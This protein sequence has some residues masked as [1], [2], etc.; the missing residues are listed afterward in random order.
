MQLPHIP[1][2]VL[3]TE[4]TGFIPKVNRVIEYAHMVYRDGKHVDEYDEL[5]AV[6]VDIPDVVQIITRI[7]PDALEGK[8]TFEQQ[9]ED[10]LKRM[11]DDTIIVGQNIL[12]DIR[13]Y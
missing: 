1:F 10:I 13:N 8:K 3:D 9:Q 11:G 5:V 7:K 12:F 6:P 2:V 4:T